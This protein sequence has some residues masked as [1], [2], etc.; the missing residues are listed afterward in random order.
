MALAHLLPHNVQSG[1][2]GLTAR[3]GFVFG[4]GLGLAIACGIGDRPH[5]RSLDPCPEPSSVGHFS[6]LSALVLVLLDDASNV[7]VT[8]G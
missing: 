8:M 5:D 3:S 1:A 7:L 6:V 4:F 2:V